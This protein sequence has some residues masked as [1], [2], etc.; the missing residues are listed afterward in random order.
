MLQLMYGQ[1][2]QRVCVLRVSDEARH[3]LKALEGFLRR[4]R[5]GAEESTYFWFNPP[6]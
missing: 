1:L 2:G 6:H 5:P 4:P 3:V